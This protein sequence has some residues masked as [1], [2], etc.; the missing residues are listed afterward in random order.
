[1]VVGAGASFELGLPTGEELTKRIADLLDIRMDGQGQR[2][3]SHNISDSFRLIKHRENPTIDVRAHIAAARSIAKAM[4][5]AR[6]IDNFLEVHAGTIGVEEAGKLAI[7]EAILAAE[8]DSVLFAK[9]GNYPDLKRISAQG[10]WHS[11]FV[12][13]LT[14]NVHFEQ[15]DEL[16]ANI[17]FVIFNYDRCVE[18]FLFNA[19]RAYYALD[20]DKAAH[21]L[22]KA[23]FIHPYGTI[24]RLPWQHSNL[25]SVMFGA[26]A[27]CHCLVRAFRGIRTFSEQMDEGGDVAAIRRSIEMAEQI[28]FLGFSYLGQNM[29][30]LKAPAV[31]L[32]RVYGTVLGFS[33]SDQAVITSTVNRTFAA[34]RHH[35]TKVELT[36]VACI[37]LFRQYSKSI[38]Q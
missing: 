10:S 24:G 3:G 18:T 15:L 14:E 23:T 19:I 20:D 26:D 6:S 5:V 11:E 21:V 37:D 32:R 38:S 2:S 9:N 34:T 8:R 31:Q 17:T 33:P 12:R 25:E 36:P 7:V 27:D 1:M 4:P 28:I 13:F 16:F 35:E 22:S 30:L 29:R